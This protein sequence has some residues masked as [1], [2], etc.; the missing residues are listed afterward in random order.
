MLSLGDLNLSSLQ[1]ITT[2]DKSSE[3]EYQ[4]KKLESLINF[5]FPISL[6]V[7]DIL[8]GWVICHKAQMC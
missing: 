4:E 8:M 2:H 3:S 1:L 7:F 5:N 6:N